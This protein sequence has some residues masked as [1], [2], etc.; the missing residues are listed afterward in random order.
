MASAS[1]VTDGSSIGDCT[2][3]DEFLQLEV[4]GAGFIYSFLILCVLLVVGILLADFVCLFVC[5][6]IYVFV[7]L[8]LCLRMFVCLLDVFFCLQFC[9]RI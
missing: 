8:F 7:L 9:V 2:D 1:S 3:D 6:C 4:R 5:F